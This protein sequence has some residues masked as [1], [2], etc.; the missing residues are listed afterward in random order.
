[1]LVFLRRL[2][3]TFERRFND[4]WNI[5]P[6]DMVGDSWAAISGNLLARVD[7]TLQRRE[8]HFLGEGGEIANDLDANSDLLQN[9]LTDP[10]ALMRLLIMM[11][12]GRVITFDQQSHQRKMKATTRLTYIFLA[13]HELEGKPVEEVQQDILTHLE[14]AQDKLSEIWGQ[15]ELDRLYNAGQVLSAISP[16]WQ[17]RLQDAMG[18]DVFERVKDQPLDQLA[19]EDHQKVVV[20]MGA[21]RP[22]PALPAIAAL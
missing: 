3:L 15:S 17:E 7:D 8:E 16:T 4:S 5:K 11:T 1:M 2:I 6:N 13:A 12:Q 21:V 19:P 18:V 10:G 20:T 14:A 22:E 9:A